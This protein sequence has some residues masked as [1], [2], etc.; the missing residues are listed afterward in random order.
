M[1]TQLIP[2]YDPTKGLFTNVDQ[3][4]LGPGFA[5]E[6]DNFYLDRPG[7]LVK[8]EGAL[9]LD[10]TNSFFHLR[11][12]FKI[13]DADLNVGSEW[14]AFEKESDGTGKLW[15]SDDTVTWAS[16]KD[17]SIAAATA[18]EM[19]LWR[20]FQI[21]RMA[22]SPSFKPQFYTYFKRKFFA[23]T[24]DHSDATPVW[25]IEDAAIQ[26]PSGSVVY[27]SIDKATSGG[28][29]IAGYYVYKITAVYD[30]VQETLLAT[31][32]W[33]IQLTD[34]DND[35]V[36][37]I[38]LDID[39]TDAN[40]SP[41]ILFYNIYRSF[42][43]AGF[44]DDD[45]N[46]QLIDTVSAQN[47]P[48]RQSFTMDRTM[49]KRWHDAESPWG[50]TDMSPV[51]T[52]PLSSPNTGDTKHRLKITSTGSFFDI[53]SNTTT[54]I[55]LNDL[56]PTSTAYF[57]EA[58]TIEL[59]TY[60]GSWSV[61]TTGLYPGTEGYGGDRCYHELSAGWEV[62]EWLNYVENHDTSKYALIIGNDDEVYALNQTP[63]TGT[64]KVV[65]FGKPLW[66][67]GAVMYFMDYGLLDKGPHPLAG[68]TSI[69]NNYRFGV[70]HMGRTFVMDVALDPAGD[71]ELHP[72]W[73]MFSE[74]DQ[75][76]V[77]PNVNFLPPLTK[78][79]GKGLGLMV[80]EGS[81][82]I[83]MF[84]RNAIGV[85]SAPRAD[86]QYWSNE[87]AAEGMGV[88]NQ[89][90]YIS[91]PLGIIF[92]SDSG[93]YLID[94]SGKLIDTPLSAPIQ[95]E[96]LTNANS[97]TADA[98]FSVMYM[99]AKRL[100]YV[101]M[102]NNQTTI[103]VLQLDSLRRE[104][105][106]WSKMELGSISAAQVNMA[107]STVDETDRFYFNGWG[108]DSI[109]SMGSGQT[110]TESFTTK[111]KSAYM[112]LGDMR[113]DHLFRY[114]HLSHKGDQAVT[115]KIYLNDGAKS[116]S[117]A[118]LATASTG[119]HRTLEFKRRARNAAIEL[120]TAAATSTDHEIRGLEMEVESL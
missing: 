74:I 35:N 42:D 14:L 13:I 68:V 48:T 5:S 56:L 118:A 113:K 18:D 106:Q 109:Y 50:A 78:R 55:V 76:D 53:V 37:L 87:M 103:H 120:T 22:I 27:T 58:Y 102:T 3:D 86:P 57:S 65:L 46:F 115:A 116:E 10:Q 26:S 81:N 32:A 79:G 108:L 47:T 104:Y 34:T 100:I 39:E 59:W 36:V 89:A 9:Y 28:S 84:Y 30:G 61:T 8:R 66:K 51:G 69:T 105:P 2:L 6:L 117:K 97:A 77:I 119:E 16:L 67:T 112:R 114:L 90:C 49:E 44:N 98:D 99:P 82:S 75:L 17:Y 21:V 94:N 33:Q 29:L 60:N 72:D 54:L 73:V 64:N 88:F 4:D 107:R 80:L 93:L 85:L 63:T 7:K 38:K 20:V 25:A 24:Y 110:G 95:D 96:W 83:V 92:A 70:Y 41:R 11:N 111:F 101:K 91:T 40:W 12:V 71:N 1:S 23:D 43:D 31:G 62:N 45:G 19:T 15:S 52:N